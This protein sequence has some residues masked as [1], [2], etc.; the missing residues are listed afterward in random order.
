[1]NL[2][3]GCL[4]RIPFCTLAP[5]MKCSA[6]YQSFGSMNSQVMKFQFTSAILNT[7]TSHTHGTLQRDGKYEH[8]TSHNNNHATVTTI[9]C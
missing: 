6:L 1:V 5:Q 2:H 4:L 8:T 3:H 7:P 9:R